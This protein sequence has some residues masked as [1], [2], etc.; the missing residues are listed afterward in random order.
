MSR[1]PIYKFIKE[2]VTGKKF[3]NYVIRGNNN[4]IIMIIINNYINNTINKSLLLFNNLFKA[5]SHI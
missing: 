2:E 1:R 3:W 5:Q 4:L